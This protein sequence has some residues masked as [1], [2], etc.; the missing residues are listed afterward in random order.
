M[1]LNC[2]VHLIQSFQKG[3]QVVV[4]KV[5]SSSLSVYTA[6]FLN[7]MLTDYLCVYIKSVHVYQNLKH[8][9][10]LIRLKV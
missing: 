6:L 2:E 5:R 3:I 7:S 1:T 8:I 10:Y 4:D 9:L